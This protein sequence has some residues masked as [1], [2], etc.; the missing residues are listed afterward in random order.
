MH[1]KQIKILTT[2]P[3]G[4]SASLNDDIKAGTAPI[5]Q[6]ILNPNNIRDNIRSVITFNSYS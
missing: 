1:S 6:A 5:K 2:K 3:M 4:F